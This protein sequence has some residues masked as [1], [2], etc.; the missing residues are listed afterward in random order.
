MLERE[1]FTVT[2]AM[3]GRDGVRLFHQKQPN[4][5]ILDVGMPDLDGWQVL[6]RIRT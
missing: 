2:E 5:V 4:L 3:L 6:E 1:G